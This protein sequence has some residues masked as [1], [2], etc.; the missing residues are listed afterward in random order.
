MA[1][2][3]GLGEAFPLQG[4]WGKHSPCR[5]FGGSIPPAG[6][7]GEELPLT[8]VLLELHN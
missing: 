5:G 8:M 3:G 4:V 1:R 2:A 7:L 6:G